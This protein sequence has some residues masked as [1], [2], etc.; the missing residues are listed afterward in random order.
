MINVVIIM[1]KSVIL[2]VEDSVDIVEIISLNLIN[3]GYHVLAVSRYEEA[4]ELIRQQQID[5][6]LLDIL[7][8]DLTGYD[9]CK[10][11]RE[12]IYCPIIFMSCLDSEEDITK[13]LE[14]GGDDYIIKPARP[15]EIVARV[16]AN[17][18]RVKQ[19]TTLQKS[20]GKVIKLG[21]LT[22]DMDKRTISSLK[23]SIGLTPLEFNILVYLHQCE[24]QM[25]SYIELF[26]N[27]W[28]TEAF[29]DYRTVKVHVNNLKNKL[30]RVS[31]EDNLITN[32][33]GEGYM[34]SI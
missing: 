20:I 24:G 2:L 34:L 8:P 6:I 33:R 15:K 5:L 1:K 16:R 25:A 27:V 12:F 31:D 4:L 17:L 14:L 28:E 9:L 10:K 29:D 23:R 18:R 13:A 7:L 22:L 19:Y 3:A 21:S 32:I 11:L 26:E 30:R